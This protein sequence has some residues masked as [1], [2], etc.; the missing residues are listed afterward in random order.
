MAKDT[1]PS[2]D[3]F[4]IAAILLAI[5]IIS[6]VLTMRIQLRQFRTKSS[7]QPL[8]YL[9]LGTLISITLGATPLLFVYLDIVW[10][11]VSYRWIVSAAVL[12]NALA[13]VSASLMLFLIYSYGIQDTDTHK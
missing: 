9:L 12:I 1:M 10:F 2:K 8:K 4:L 11:Q 7:V 5:S 13:K 6:N 3:I